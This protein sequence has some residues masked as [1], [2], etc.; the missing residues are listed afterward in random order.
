VGYPIYWLGDGL[1][2]FAGLAAFGPA[3]NV[4]DLLVAYTTGY[5]AVALPLPAGG[6]GGVDAAMVFSL[7]LVG[8]D[9]EQALLG[10]AVYRAFTFWLPVAPALAVV[11]TLP[12]LAKR[13]DDIAEGRAGTQVVPASA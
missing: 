6:A 11:P 1:C 9:L 10:V 13:L 8:I 7:T 3:P 5:I 4:V 2:L 12:R